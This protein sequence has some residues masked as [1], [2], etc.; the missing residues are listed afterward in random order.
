M[1]LDQWIVLVVPSL[2]TVGSTIYA[3]IAIER[4]KRK[5]ARELL[6]VQTD[7]TLDSQRRLDELKNSLALQ[8]E[9]EIERLKAELARENSMHSLKAELKMRKSQ[10]FVD[11]LIHQVREVHLK[12]Q[13]YTN[14]S[15]R[16]LRNS[17]ID[18]SDG[19]YE[20]AVL[21][22]SALMRTISEGIAWVDI[23]ILSELT[24]SANK[25]FNAL[26]EKQEVVLESFISPPS[27]ELAAADEFDEDCAANGGID[28]I[29]F[30]LM[31]LCRKLNA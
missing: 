30:N 20:N 26:W 29:L 8:R 16:E 14:A 22:I 5:M 11:N 17:S 1:D 24:V 18:P 4:Y 23:R 7:M 31:I 3:G 15:Y 21:S 9:V 28:D 10:E 27:D 25:L 12:V 2:L 13:S 6:Q 19:L